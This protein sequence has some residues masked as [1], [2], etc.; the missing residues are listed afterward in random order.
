[1]VRR[2][3]REEGKR[4]RRKSGGKWVEVSGGQGRRGGSLSFIFVFYALNEKKGGEKEGGDLE[5]GQ[6]VIVP[7]F[8]YFADRGGQK[9]RR[10]KKILGPFFLS[11]F[12]FPV[13]VSTIVGAGCEY[14][15]FFYQQQTISNKK[16]CTCS[17]D[18]FRSIYTPCMGL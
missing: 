9:K 1:M 4:R 10:R 16:V 3:K 14:N 11:C 12:F 8:C 18:F 15:G 7:F 6:T 17:F 2:C 13:R 5:S